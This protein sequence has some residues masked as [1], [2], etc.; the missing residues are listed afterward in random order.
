LPPHKQGCAND[1]KDRKTDE[2]QGGADKSSID[3]KRPTPPRKIAPQMALNKTVC[4]SMFG[5]SQKRASHT[6]LKKRRLLSSKTFCGM[7]TDA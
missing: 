4:F 6:P 1:L 5:M 7:P 3:N 2:W